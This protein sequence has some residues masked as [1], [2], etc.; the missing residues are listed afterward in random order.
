MPENL[1]RSIFAGFRFES[2][3]RL[4]QSFLIAQGFI[5]FRSKLASE[6]VQQKYATQKTEAAKLRYSSWI[7]KRFYH[8]EAGLL[9]LL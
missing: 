9:K 6:T 3:R 8:S 7:S 2:D 5:T 1:V 4:K